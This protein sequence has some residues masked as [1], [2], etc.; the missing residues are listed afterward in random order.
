MPY[1][2]IINLRTVLRL[3]SIPASRGT[4][5]HQQYAEALKLH[6]D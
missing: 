3:A 4:E 6:R 1:F 5:V 2:A